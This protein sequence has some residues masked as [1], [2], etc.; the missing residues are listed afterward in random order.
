MLSR[1]LTKNI[2]AC[3]GVRKERIRRWWSSWVKFRLSKE[4]ST[5]PNFCRTASRI[6]RQTQA[7]TF[8]IKQR[9]PTRTVRVS[10]RRTLR[11]LT[12]SAI[13]KW[14]SPLIQTH[15]LRDSN[16]SRLTTIFSQVYRPEARTWSWMQTRP[17]C[18]MKMQARV[19]CRFRIWTS[20]LWLTLSSLG[21][22]L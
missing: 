7:T 19:L 3:V 17:R 14:M 16:W 1:G 4:E 8:R 11:R 12:R 9:W 10:C 21:P 15:L 5:K 20:P 2:S 22:S 13:C 6:A 18:C